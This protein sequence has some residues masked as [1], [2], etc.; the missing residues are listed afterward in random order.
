MV[1][2]IRLLRFCRR[3][4]VS[5]TRPKNNTLLSYVTGY[6]FG[7]SF[8]WLVAYV[9]CVP[10]AS[11]FRMEF[12]F[13]LG[14]CVCGWVCMRA[15]QLTWSK[16]YKHGVVYIRC[17]P[18]YAVLYAT[19]EQWVVGKMAGLKAKRGK[20]E[21]RFLLNGWDTNRTTERAKEWKCDA[22]SL[23][24]VIASWNCK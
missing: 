15:F 17:N 22:Y 3:R 12:D 18:L 14:K 19:I 8:F 11:I 23:A 21:C 2:Y 1:I 16:Y 7:D 9:H 20:M 10:I 4:T 24:L 6:W 13:M 5:S